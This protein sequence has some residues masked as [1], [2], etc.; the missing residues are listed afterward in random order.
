MGECDVGVRRVTN[1]RG[2]RWRVTKESAGPSALSLQ[3]AVNNKLF[4]QWQLQRRRYTND[5]YPHVNTETA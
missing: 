5:Y 2:V 1:R 3:V 4:R